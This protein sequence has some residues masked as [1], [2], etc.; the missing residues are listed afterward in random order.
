MGISGVN[1]VTLQPGLASRLPWHLRPGQMVLVE[2]LAIT[3]PQ[4]VVRI[5]GQTFNA[6]GELPP[7]PANFWALIEDITGNTLKVRQLS[8]GTPEEYS[9]EDV[10]RLLQL[11][12]DEDTVQLLEEMLKKGLPLERR[13]ISRLLAEGQELPKEERKSFWA[14]RLYLETLDIRENAEKLR[15]AINYLSRHSDADPEGQQVLNQARVL[16]PGGEVIRFFTFRGTEGNGELYLFFK[17]AGSS[18]GEPPSRLVIQ[19]TTPILGQTWV[20]LGGGPDGLTVRAA[21]AQERFLKDAS[22]AAETLQQKLMEAGYR[23]NHVEVAVRK[24]QNVFDF[25]EPPSIPEYRPLDTVV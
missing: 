24:V 8:A 12:A 21:V 14:A 9:I 7:G 5:A 13:V 16:I 23:V 6:Q 15:S 1:R 4:A 20:N 2:T 22:E 19:V 25:L 17:E 11:P 10:A 3:G 18:I